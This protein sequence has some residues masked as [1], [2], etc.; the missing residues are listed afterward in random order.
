MATFAELV[1]AS[2]NTGLVEKIKIATLIAADS[3][4]TEGQGVAHHQDR[5]RWAAKVFSEPDT[6]ATK[7]IW[8]VLI[9]NRTATLAQI[10][11][12]SDAAV[13]SAV[14]AAVAVVIAGG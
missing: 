5:V 10:T 6:Q 8:P 9:Q 13:Q 7:M 12:A 4:R 11:G 2:G 1:T 3:V 14:D